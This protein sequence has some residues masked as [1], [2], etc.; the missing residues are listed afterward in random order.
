[1]FLLRRVPIIDLV[2]FVKYNGGNTAYITYKIIN[3][4]HNSKPISYCGRVPQNQTLIKVSSTQVH[5][6]LFFRLPLCKF[7]LH[8]SKLQFALQKSVTFMQKVS[9]TQT[10]VNCLK[11]L[12]IEKKIFQ[13]Y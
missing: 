8:G 7:L 3:H 2:N 11:N 9:N 4:Q 12:V 5:F 6:H 1:M 13:F 10:Q